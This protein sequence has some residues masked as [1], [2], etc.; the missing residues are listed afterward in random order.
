[1]PS[2]Q[3]MLYQHL[4]SE[5]STSRRPGEAYIDLE[6]RESDGPH[7]KRVGRCVDVVLSDMCEPA[8][9]KAYMTALKD[10]L[11]RLMNTSGNIFRDHWKSMVWL[12]SREQ[13]GPRAVRD[14]CVKIYADAMQELCNSALDFALKTLKPGGHFVCKFYMGKEDKAFEQRLKK[15]FRTYYR[16]KPES[17]RKESKEAYFVAKELVNPEAAKRVGEDE[18]VEEFYDPLKD[19]ERYASDDL[20]DIEAKNR[21]K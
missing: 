1:M 13:G 7:Q 4:I 2:V 11:D 16:S 9:M 12:L 10:P 18:P 6:K 14:E 5:D 21:D 8:P 19:D 20:P 3:N 17:S 15:G